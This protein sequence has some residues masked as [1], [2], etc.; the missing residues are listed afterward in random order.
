MYIYTLSL[1]IFYIYFI[2]ISTY[3]IILLFIFFFLVREI[4][5]VTVPLHRQVIPSVG[6]KRIADLSRRLPE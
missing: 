5:Y 6:E 2:I 4:D 3:S 1:C